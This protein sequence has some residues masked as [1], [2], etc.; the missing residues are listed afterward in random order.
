MQKPPV[1]WIL[2]VED[3]PEIRELLGTSLEI[4]FG[5]RI[6][7]MAV[8]DG[9][10][11]TSKVSF[12]AYDCIITDLKMP[13]KEGN[14]FIESTRQ[15]ALNQ[16]TPTI[17]FTGHPDPEL[18]ARFPMCT[19]LDKSKSPEEVVKVV[20]TQLKLGR[21]DKRVG[22]HILN[23][24]VAAMHR[25][26]E[27]ALKDKGELQ[28]PR[29]KRSGE[30]Y[31]LTCTR[32]LSVKA[33]GS[34]CD[35]TISF[36]QQLLLA[37][38]QNAGAD[39]KLSLDVLLTGAS[40]TVFHHAFRNLGSGNFVIHETKIL[41]LAGQGKAPEL[42]ARKGIIIKIQTQAGTAELVALC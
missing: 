26:F 11:A 29:A 17:V 12:Q 21:T 23:S 10:E 36:D 3:E 40:N 19:F 16:H 13:R 35:F 30:D 14:A 6:K 39:K 27:T 1:K 34:V 38:N 37:L 20:E 28:T 9:V 5:D 7:V 15:S 2:I 24:T 22:A 41:A 32:Y 42:N 31:P 18:M 4:Q 33:S 25:L 8:G